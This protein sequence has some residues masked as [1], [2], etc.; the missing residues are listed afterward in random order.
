[1]STFNPAG[2]LA[3]LIRLGC[4]HGSRR[5]VR[6]AIILCCVV[7]APY[8]AAQQFREVPLPLDEDAFLRWVHADWA[9]IDNDGDL[10]ILHTSSLCNVYTTGATLLFVNEGNRGF[11][12]RRAHNVLQG[13]CGALLRW[14]DFDGDGDVDLLFGGHHTVRTWP[15]FK[16]EMDTR[17]YRNDGKGAFEALDNVDLYDCW[18][19]TADWGDFDNDGDLDIMLQGGAGQVNFCSRIY[20]N[21]GQNSFRELKL[22]PIPDLAG[23]VMRWNDYDNDGDLDALVGSPILPSSRLFENIDGSFR[24]LAQLRLPIVCA[25]SA[26][27]GDYNSDGRPDLFFVGFM[28]HV[29]NRNPYGS[30]YAGLYRNDGGA[31]FAEQTDNEFIGLLNA[32]ASWGDCDNDGDLDLLVMGYRRIPPKRDVP[33]LQCLLTATMVRAILA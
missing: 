33:D 31:H 30:V 28:N 9:D 6:L 14:A 17:L 10:D 8:L 27:W 7:S 1:M 25:G 12:R 21:T 29:D 3:Q 20:W 16:A 26:E 13:A 32:S 22:L 19:A 15:A 24:M 2:L 18:N 5:Q 23:G 11:Y 4:T